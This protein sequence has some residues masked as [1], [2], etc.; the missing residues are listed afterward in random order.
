MK[1]EERAI[2]EQSALTHSF[3]EG[4]AGIQR[5]HACQLREQR[6]RLPGHVPF[7]LLLIGASLTFRDRQT[8]GKVLL[9]LRHVSNLVIEL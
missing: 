4:L 2:V 1:K 9:I 5:R 6:E 8:L 7:G 3:S